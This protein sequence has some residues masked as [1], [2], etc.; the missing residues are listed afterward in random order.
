MLD[1]S[2]LKELLSYDSGTGKFTWRKRTSNRISTGDL[3]GTLQGIGYI[4]ISIDAKLYFAHRLA[5]LYINGEFPK[6]QIDH[7]NGIR[8][9]NR[10]ENLRDVS[11][12]ENAKNQKMKNT[13]K[14][15]VSGVSWHKGGGK[16]QVKILENYKQIYLGLFGDWFEAVCARKS[17][18]NKYGY[19]VN[20][21]R[22]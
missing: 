12:L 18:E 5:W 10:I 21:G 16:W 8:H 14:S 11:C 6:R 15:G 2:R 17:A 13:N 19:H 20:C 4:C 22:K 1:Q 3:A 7:I 9:D